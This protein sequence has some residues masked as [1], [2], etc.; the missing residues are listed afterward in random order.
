MS[1]ENSKFV[2]E[3]ETLV[4]QIL[5]GNEHAVNK[6]VN[7]HYQWLLTTTQIKFPKLQSHQDVVHDAFILVIEKI[8]QQ[9][10]KDPSKFKAF[11]RTIAINT[12]HQYYRK[13]Q[14]FHSSLSEEMMQQ[15]DSQV[16]SQSVQY[17]WDNQVQLAKKMIEELAMERDQ[18]ILKLHY[19]EG[20]SKPEVCNTLNLS[21]THFDRVISRARNRLKALIQAHQCKKS[22]EE[23]QQAQRFNQQ[24]LAVVGATLL[25]LMEFLK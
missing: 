8:K 2:S 1:V 19:F 17:D 22:S 10:I 9:K 23:S 5:E 3:D 6:M 20:M 14:R 21:V 11:L 7:K 18:T 4:A 15:I 25:S 12:A 16:T 24:G 13:D